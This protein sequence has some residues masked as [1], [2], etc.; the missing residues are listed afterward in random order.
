VNLSSALIKRVLEVTD[1]DTWARV[2][3]HYLPAEYHQLY[4]SID[5][6]VTK[7]H[8]LPSI[9]EL[10]LSVRD[11]STRDKVYALEEIENDSEPFLL[12][13]YLKNEY[14][15]KETF[16]QI[17]RWIE[18]SIA[19]ESAEEVVRTLQSI[20]YDIEQKVEIQPEEESMQKLS[21]FESDEEFARHIVL[22]LNSDFDAVY[23]FLGNDYIMMGGK[24]GSGKSITCNNLA[25][26]AIASGK[27][28]VYFSIEMDARQVLQRHVAI[29][30]NIPYKKIRNKNLSITEW[31]KLAEYWAS[32][33]DNGQE[34]LQTYFV[35]NDFELFHKALSREELVGAQLHIVYDPHLT[36]GKM[37]N[38]LN[39]FVALG[40]ELGVIIVD[41][42]NQM[43][44]DN[45][46]KGTSGM[47]DW[48]QQIEI[49]KGLKQIAQDYE[50]PVFT[51]YQ[52][53]KDGEARFA[54]GI[55]D[56]ADAAMVLEAHDNCITFTITKM[57]NADDDIVFTSEM[58]WDTLI[59]G[60]GNAI[61]PEPE[62]DDEDIAPKKR[63]SKSGFANKASKIYDDPPF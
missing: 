9:E 15:Q 35:H 62:V 22:G 28:A 60:P 56:A 38:I 5:R 47:Y 48:T 20:A 19:F 63:K 53:D 2:R 50:I 45:N 41:Y 29:M 40:E 39:K 31:H 51:P 58:N 1:F 30:T 33:Y 59:I 43:E 18:G 24:R 57:R 26:T 37:R 54:K 27:S 23:D 4:D 3:K 14:A 55:L 7:Y 36:I 42:I 46:T 10:K 32:R 12:L 49:S 52:T 61:P 25:V 16:T 34:H 21:L 17:D 8:K 11:S 13:D 44:K 6:H